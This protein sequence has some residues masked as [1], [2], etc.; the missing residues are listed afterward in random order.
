MIKFLYDVIIKNEKEY[1]KCLH[2]DQNEY[3]Q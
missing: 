2:M 1:N 3:T